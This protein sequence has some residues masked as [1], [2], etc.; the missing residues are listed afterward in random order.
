MQQH[1]III[2]YKE[3]SREDF[4]SHIYCVTFSLTNIYFSFIPHLL[5]AC[6]GNENPDTNV[7]HFEEDEQILTGDIPLDI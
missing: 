4:S 2:L 6:K 1:E 3:I 7:L 5:V